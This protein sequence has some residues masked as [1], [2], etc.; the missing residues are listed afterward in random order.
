[1]IPVVGCGDGPPPRIRTLNLTRTLT[2]SQLGADRQASLRHAQGVAAATAAAAIQL[3]AEGALRREGTSA[4]QPRTVLPTGIQKPTPSFPL[5]TMPPGYPT[6]S[7]RNSRVGRCM[8]YDYITVVFMCVVLCWIGWIV[9]SNS[10]RSRPTGSGSNLLRREGWRIL[11]YTRT[12]P[13]EC[14]AP[15]GN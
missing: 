13:R 10:K 1:M 14:T 2:L 15:Y 6:G 12:F 9:S 7:A 11:F 5:F 8:L 4:C 3:G